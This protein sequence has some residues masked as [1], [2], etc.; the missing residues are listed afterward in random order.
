MKKIAK[1]IGKILII[2]LV[3]ITLILPLLIGY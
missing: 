2:T 3:A 1:K